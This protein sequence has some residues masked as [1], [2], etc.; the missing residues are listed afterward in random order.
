M[1]TSLKQRNYSSIFRTTTHLDQFLHRYNKKD[2]FQTL[3]PLQLFL[4]SITLKAAQP[5][6]ILISFQAALKAVLKLLDL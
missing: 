5:A 1:K 4:Q 6:Q 3:T 2:L